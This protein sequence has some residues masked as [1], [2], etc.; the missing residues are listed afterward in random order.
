LSFSDGTAEETASRGEPLS[1]YSKLYARKTL[2]LRFGKARIV[3]Q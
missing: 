2:R 3:V 1:A